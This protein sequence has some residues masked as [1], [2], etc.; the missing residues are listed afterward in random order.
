MVNRFLLIFYFPNNGDGNYLKVRN[1][2]EYKILNVKICVIMTSS[3]IV[4]FNT[5]IHL[6]I[7]VL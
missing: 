4:I 1:K 2:N 3:R 6:N 5:L 7:E